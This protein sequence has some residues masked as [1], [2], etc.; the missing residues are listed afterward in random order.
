[1]LCTYLYLYLP[2]YI[3]IYLSLAAALSLAWGPDYLLIP[4]PQPAHVWQYALRLYNA[5]LI[6]S[7]SL[8]VK[9]GRGG[10]GGGADDGEGVAN[11]CFKCLINALWHCLLTPLIHINAKRRQCCISA[12][13]SQL[14]VVP[15]LAKTHGQANELAP[16]IWD[17]KLGSP[18]ELSGRS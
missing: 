7:T 5:R 12:S 4:Q 18:S 13:G 14:G 2:V 17:L 8:L 10:N 1:M 9:G 6:G 11:A 16:G 3:D 15:V